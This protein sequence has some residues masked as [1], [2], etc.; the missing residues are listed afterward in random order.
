[1]ASV[2]HTPMCPK[3]QNWQELLVHLSSSVIHKAER[4][5]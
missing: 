2:T 1:M 3:M 4:V 5:L